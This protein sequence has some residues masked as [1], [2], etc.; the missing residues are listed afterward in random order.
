M[1]IFSSKFKKIRNIIVVMVLAIA[2]IHIIH[3]LTLDR[4]IQ[5]KEISFYSKNL[6]P[7]LCGYRI[8]FIT[9]SHFISEKQNWEV[10]N[11]LNNR[12]LDL[13]VL[14]GDFAWEVDVMKRTVE[15][16]SHIEATDGIYGVEGNHDSYRH[17]FV[18][19]EDNGITPLSNSGV[20]IREGLFL[21]G[22]EDLWNRNPNINKA[23]KNANSNDFVLL[24]SHNPDVTMQQD[25]SLIDL[26]LSGHTH[27]GHISFFG[28][29][30]PYFTMSRGITAYGQRFRSGFALSK[31]DTPVFVSRGAGAYRLGVYLPRV[32]ARP[33][34]VIITLVHEKT[35]C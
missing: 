3:A 30:A 16:L 32:F 1:L 28:I 25:T 8:A 9:D 13:V 17:L 26:T 29:W 27:G 33:Q 34:V 10:V 21:A 11:E 12:D 31:D 23:I 19:M 15:I 2:L 5:Y 35:E 24:I 14:G 20:H 4:I 6:A 7:E 18:A 22:V